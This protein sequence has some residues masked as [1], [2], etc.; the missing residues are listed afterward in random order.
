MKPLDK[1]RTSAVFGLPCW[2]R[3]CRCHYI[4][5]LPYYFRFNVVGAR[6]VRPSVF[7]HESGDLEIRRCY[8]QKH[9]KSE[10]RV[11]WTPTIAA[12]GH[13]DTDLSTSQITPRSQQIQLT[14]QHS[15]THEGRPRKTQKKQCLHRFCSYVR[16]AVETASGMP[17]S[18]DPSTNKGVH[19]IRETLSGLSV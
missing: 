15:V 5:S 9:V 8:F 2:P 19:G 11:G 6:F 13:A 18:E 14:R 16:A 1:H 10:R 3:P 7:C 17:V 4:L 12:V